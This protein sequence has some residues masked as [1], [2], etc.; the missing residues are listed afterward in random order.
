MQLQDKYWQQ[1]LNL[2]EMFPVRSEWK[3]KDQDETGN[4]TKGL[5]S[6]I[7]QTMTYGFSSSEF[8]LN[9]LQQGG[10]FFFL[11]SDVLVFDYC[12]YK[13]GENILAQFLVK[14]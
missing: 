6:N 3:P 9:Q 8:K 1:N 2:A 11:R 4:D 5:L 14:H 13:F 10:K 12:D 7:I